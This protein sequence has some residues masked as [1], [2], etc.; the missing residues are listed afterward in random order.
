MN[1]QGVGAC[2]AT[3]GYGNA[4]SDGIN[5][6]ANYTSSF[7]GTSSA[8]PIVASAAALLVEWGR[9]NHTYGAAPGYTLKPGEVRRLL[10]A[11]G[12]PQASGDTRHIG[13]L[14]DLGGAF[15]RLLPSAGSIPQ[16][17]VASGTQFTLKAPNA[18]PGVLGG[19]LTYKWTQ[20]SG[21]SVT[22]ASPTSQTTTVSGRTGPA[23][24]GFQLRVTDPRRQTST[25]ATTVTVA[26]PGTVVADAGVD[27]PI[28]SGN[29]SISIPLSSSGSGPSG[30]NYKWMLLSSTDGQGG[31]IKEPTV[32]NTSTNA[33]TPRGDQTYTY[34]LTVKSGGSSASD[35][36]VVSVHPK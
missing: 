8:S 17:T 5:A 2:V 18:K 36:V 14:P 3:S 21:P 24:L 9:E 1:V 10:I 6:N 13:P 12:T 19:A 34:R 29:A 31:S 22:I 4:Y 11:T 33:F 27:F 25:S 7:N 32:A 23:S 30:V 16:Q 35:D 26:S 28:I 20:T 15:A